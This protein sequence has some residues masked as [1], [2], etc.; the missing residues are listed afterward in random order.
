MVQAQENPLVSD[1]PSDSGTTVSIH[2]LVLLTASDQITRHRV[3]AESQPIVG[4]LLG[5]Q[6][7]RELTVEHAFA[8]ALG[9]SE[10]GKYNFNQDWLETRTQQCKNAPFARILKRLTQ[11]RS[12]CSQSTG[13]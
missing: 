7:G 8:A 13:P 6:K 9:T 5:Q 4:V 12:R 11:L 10:D 1:K 2:P 3:R